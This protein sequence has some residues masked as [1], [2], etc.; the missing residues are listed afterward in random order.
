MGP[1]DHYKPFADVYGTPTTEEGRPSLM[2]RKKAK[3]LTYSPGEQ[4]ARNVGVV[5]QCDECDKWRLLF[6]KR[7]LSVK[8]RA[9]LEEVIAEI[10][11]TCGATVDDLVLPDNLKSI[12]IRS[13]SCSDPIEKIYYS[14]YKDDLI[15]IHCG[16]ANSLTTPTSS[17]TFYPYCELFLIGPNPYSPVKLRFNLTFLCVPHFWTYIYAMEIM[18]F[19]FMFMHIYMLRQ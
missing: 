15:W 3:T 2:Q 10:S 7:K 13:H 5:V 12:G 6:S 19:V 4:H 1:D 11:Y 18:L 9:Q 14:A 8:E 16:S 17:D